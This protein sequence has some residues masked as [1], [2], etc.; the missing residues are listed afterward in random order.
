[1][2]KKTSI[3]TTLRGTLPAIE[4][5]NTWYI[6]DQSCRLHMSPPVVVSGGAPMQARQQLPRRCK[7][8]RPPTSCFPKDR[9]AYHHSSSMSL[10]WRR[11]TRAGPPLRLWTLTVPARQPLPRQGLFST[12]HWLITACLKSDGR[13]DRIGEWLEIV[14]YRWPKF[15]PW[16]LNAFVSKRAAYWTGLW[17]L[18][19][20]H[21]GGLDE[22]CLHGALGIS[23]S[24][25]IGSNLVISFAGAHRH[26]VVV[27]L[28]ESLSQTET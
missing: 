15:L 22:V 9:G 23:A 7:L 14:K 21:P 26:R 28:C 17:L 12:F 18:Q 5:I 16:F 4:R 27:A 24:G 11:T 25:K 3:R 1:M 19:R 6:P 20:C 10:F 8:S 13:D 2:S